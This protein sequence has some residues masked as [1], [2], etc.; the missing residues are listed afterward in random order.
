MQ[1]THL[2]HQILYKGMQVLT[3]IPTQYNPQK[4]KRLTLS[5]QPQVARYETVGQ[6]VLDY[7]SG[8][9]VLVIYDAEKVHSFYLDRVVLLQPGTRFSL[10]PMTGDCCVDLLTAEAEPIMLDTIPVEHLQ[11][12][13]KGLQLQKIYTL[14][15]QEFLHNF[16]FR[17][18]AHQPYELV[19]VQ[20]GTLHNLVQGKDIVLPRQSFMIIDSN[21]WHT[22]YSDDAV[23]FLTISFWAEDPDLTRITNQPFSVMPQWEDVL[24]QLVRQDRHSPYSNDVTQSLLSILL[25][26]LLENAHKLPSPLVHS[27]NQIVDTAVRIISEHATKKLTLEDLAARV[28]VS[29]PYLYKLFQTHL[30]ISPGKYIAKIRAEECK[31]LL[32]DKQLSMGQV[33][34]QMGFSS[35]QQFSRQFKNTCGITPSQYAN[36]VK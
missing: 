14:L 12:V 25:I 3:Q 7:V 16:Y 15:Y 20:Q 5:V 8:M 2:S 19:Y 13:P 6:V 10:L 32:R 1:I 27:E 22:Q 11:A 21:H 29:V 17:G 31:V 4:A 9:S 35:L 23:S 24:R 33:A 28:H 18:E 34:T 36:S 30:G 26:Q